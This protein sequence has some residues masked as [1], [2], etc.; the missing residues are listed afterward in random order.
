[1]IRS[2]ARTAKLKR[3]WNGI[4]GAY[5]CLCKKWERRQQYI[6]GKYHGLTPGEGGI[7]RHSGIALKAGS[8]RLL[9][10]S[11][12]PSTEPAEPVEGFESIFKCITICY[13]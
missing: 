9:D 10:R 3:G 8:P 4:Q 2:L 5:A 1:M 11:S 6:S 13:R 7:D 12:S